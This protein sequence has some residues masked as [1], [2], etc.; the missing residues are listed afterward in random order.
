MEQFRF[1]PFSYAGVILA[2][3][4]S[5]G[6]LPN[7]PL[8]TNTLTLVTKNASTYTLRYLWNIGFSFSKHKND[9]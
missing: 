8:D 9:R 3:S 1:L 7:A 5:V 6:A 2:G 4:E